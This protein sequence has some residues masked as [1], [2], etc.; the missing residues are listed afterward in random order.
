MNS[1][2]ILRFAKKYKLVS[3]LGGACVSCGNSNLIELD[4]HHINQEL[5]E[6]LISKGLQDRKMKDLEIE[7]LKCIVLCRN[8]HR[9]V[10]STPGMQ[11]KRDAL[12]YKKI[13]EC[14]KCGYSDN[15]SSLDFH[16]RDPTTKRFEIGA[17]SKLTESVKAELDKCSVLCANCH[18]KEHHNIS[19]PEIELIVSK[20]NNL[21][22]FNSV[23]INKLLEMSSL[24]HGVAQI[25]KEMGIAKS[26]I[27][28]AFSRLGIETDFNRIDHSEIISLHYCGMSAIDISR[29][30]ECNKTTVFN[31][32]KN[33]KLKPNKNKTRPSRKQLPTKQGIL[34]MRPKPMKEI[35]K[36]FGVS[37]QTLYDILKS[38]SEE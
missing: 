15:V 36:T 37:R 17:R 7:A 12:K 5:K 30:L 29:K 27:S 34:E 33:N 18:M 22:T 6:Y 31:C 1:S 11:I 16:H 24:G 2:R 3:M 4:F 10:H 32:L 19:P 20:S 13:F 25:S 14:E 38:N 35:A 8:C 23:D 28:N 21:K 9:K 26:T